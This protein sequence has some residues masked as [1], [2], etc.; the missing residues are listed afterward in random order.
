MPFATSFSGLSGTAVAAIAAGGV[1]VLVTLHLLRVFRREVAVAYAPLWL[2][3]PATERASRFAR[4]LRRLLSLLLALAIF[5]LVLLGAANPAPS[6]AAAGGRS[7]VV[8]I[9]RSASMSA[10]DEPGTRIGAA[11]RRALDVVGGLTADD[12][13]LIASFAADASAES[14]FESDPDRLARAVA[15]VHGG[16]EAADL[17]RALA[18]ATAVLRGR[19]RPTVVLVSDGAFPDDARRSAPAHI[20]LRYAPVGRRGQNLAIVSL[21]A[22]R[23]VADPGAVDAALTIANFGSDKAATTV[24]L[25]S[26]S[27]VAVE[28]LRFELAPGEQRRHQL[29]SVFAAGARLEARL[30]AGDGQPL[31]DDLPL[32]DHAVATVPPLPRRRVL[33]VGGT[34]LYLDA[35]LLGLGRSVAVE[36]LSAQAAEAA[37]TRFGDYDLVIFDG[38]APSPAPT[39]GR[40]LYLDPHGPGSPFPERGTVRDPVIAEARRDHPLLRQIDLADVNIAEAR[41]LALAPGDVAVAGSFGVPLLIARD[42]PGLRLVA[43]SFD[44]RRSDLPMRPAF[45]LLVAS[46]LAWAVRDHVDPTLAAAASTIDVRESNTTPVTALAVGG[47]TLPPPD[48]PARRPP[49]RIPTVA[50]VLATALALLEWLSSHRRWT[51]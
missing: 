44:P 22:R 31:A 5:G 2:G 41:R 32:D 23:L 13:A 26:A 20:D 36:R 9:D 14:G 25:S 6:T 37:G 29:G 39:S 19:P 17:P 24:E 51:A 15:A 38:V 4:W 50:L 7:V 43:I 34:N 42:R 21:A 16:R 10:R 47:R 40:F 28:R 30:L 49:L 48:P 46:T 35:A 11:R 12:R 3:A 33:R 8:L 18:F 1:A 27:G 45:P